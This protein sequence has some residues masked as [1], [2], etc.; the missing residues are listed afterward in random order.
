VLPIHVEA[1]AWVV[2]RAELLASL[3]Y[4]GGLLALLHHRRSGS[5]GALVIATLLVMLGTFAKENAATLLAAPVLA[6]ALLPGGARERRRDGIALAALAG[7][8]LVYGAVRYAA[9]GPP[10]ASAAGDL[11]DNPLATLPLGGRLLGAVSVLGRYLALTLWPHPLSID[12][13]YDALGIGA[14]FMF[15]RYSAVALLGVAALAALAFRVGRVA[16][17]VLLLA[18]AAYS[19]V[20]NT[21]LLIGTVM[22]ERL[23]Y[24]PTAGLALAIA[25]AL[26]LAKPAAL[27]RALMVGIVALSVGYGVVSTRRAADWQSAI[28]IFESA[29][30]AH[31]RSARAHMELGGAY[32]HAGRGSDAEREFASAVEI[33]PSYAAAWYNLGNLRARSGRLDPAAD[34]YHRALEHSPRLV[35]AWYNLG[36][37]EQM[38]GRREAAIDAFSRAAEIAPADPEIQ[39]MLGVLRERNR[40][41][42]N[43]PTGR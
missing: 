28:T 43:P 2:G 9:G 18:A 21:V 40:D 32:G 25:P 8:L 20:S 4:C 31:P 33:L 10:S 12:Y 24:L 7:G 1:V 42:A 37:V 23:F 17:F 3:A 6:T 19:L 15:D 41:I 16:A 39:R 35:Q 38:R 5:V 34:A 36:L 30:R 22:A 29:T 14:G 26:D 27:R 13:S 11:L